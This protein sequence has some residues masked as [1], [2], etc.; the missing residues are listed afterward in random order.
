MTALAEPAKPEFF[1]Q[2]FALEQPDFD[3]LHRPH[4]WHIDQFI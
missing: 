2:H 4:G 1:D 3:L